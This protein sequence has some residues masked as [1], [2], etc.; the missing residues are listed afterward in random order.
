[1]VQDSR[2]RP[3]IARKPFKPRNC[4]PTH[5]EILLWNH[6]RGPITQSSFSAPATLVCRFTPI[7]LQQQ[8]RQ[9][10]CFHCDELYTVDYACKKLFF[11]ELEMGPETTPMI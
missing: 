9:G 11:I 1:M 7:E 8:R 4:E 5:K 6:P 3:V 10:L 2:S